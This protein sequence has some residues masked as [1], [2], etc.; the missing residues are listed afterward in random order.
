V[1][2]TGTDLSS[3]IMNWRAEMQPDPG[4]DKAVVDLYRSGVDAAL[5]SDVD[6]K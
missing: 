4:V 1:Y 3:H 2:D 5:R 6:V